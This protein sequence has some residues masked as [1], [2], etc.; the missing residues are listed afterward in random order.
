MCWQVVP[1]TVLV[2]YAVVYFPN[3]LKGIE[4]LVGPK[5]RTRAMHLL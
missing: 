2:V 3:F 5:F 4:M 1:A